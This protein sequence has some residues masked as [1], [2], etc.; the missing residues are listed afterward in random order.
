ML[1]VA[2]VHL[3]VGWLYSSG[4]RRD[5]LTI[6]QRA[7]DPEILVRELSNDT[8]TLEAPRPR[9]DIGHPG[10]LGLYW[11]GGYSQVN[12]VVDVRDGKVLRLFTHLKGELPPLCPDGSLDTCQAVSL[13]SYAF[14]DNPADVGLDFREIEY[15]SP[16]GAMGGWTIES[17]STRWTLHIH[18]WG[19]HRREALR[20]LPPINAEGWNSLVIDYRNDEDA[21]TDPSGHYRFG[22]SEWE[23]VEAAV[24]Q[25]S[26]M[27]ATD[28]VL[29]GYS[30]G[31]AHAMAFLERSELA[32]KVGGLVFDSPNINLASTVR[33]GSRGARLPFVRIPLT[34]L[35]IEFGMW[36]S[37]LRWKVDW[38][39]TNYL[40]R[41]PETIGVPILVFHGSADRRVPVAVSRTLA[42]MLGG[43]VT[44]VET[45]AAGHV[46]SWNA[47]RERYERALTGFL[48][49]L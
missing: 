1:G 23:D 35:M 44:Y 37:D 16:L 24:A 43:L 14:P 6:R 10:T 13:G 31:A 25:L 19:A 49:G 48:R 28:I 7:D 33:H 21:P 40:E 39:A 11:D 29:V 4:F 12:D 27:G 34:R 17:G 46:M 47:D 20:L 45:P 42:D 8:I 22:L 38:V 18:G 9:Q 41:A 5:A 3:V 26:A 32:D 2:A 36:I 15:T 30:T